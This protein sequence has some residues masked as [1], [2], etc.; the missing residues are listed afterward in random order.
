M[1]INQHPIWT[2]VTPYKTKISGFKKPFH[3]LRIYLAKQVAKLYP[4]SMFVGVTGSVGKTTA[5][6]AAAAVLSQKYKI[7]TT[8]PNLDPIL[9]IPK[10]ILSIRPGIKKVILEMGVEYKGEMDF[11]L[12]LVRPKTAI[13]TRISHA[14]S[15]FLGSLDEIYMEKG[16]LIKQLPS[17]G[18]A[19]LNGDDIYCRKL[20]E[21]TKAAVVFFGRDQKTATIWAG[22][23]KIENFKT[24]FELNYGVER[25]KVNYQLLGEHQIYPALAAAALGVVEDISLIKIKKALESIT[26]AEHRLQALVGP[27]GSTILDDTYNSSP[28]AA[29]A[30]IDTLTQVPARHRILVLGEMRELGVYSEKLHRDLAKKISKEKIDMVILGQGETTYIADELQ[31]LGFIDE[32]LLTNLQNSQIVSYLLKTL[33]RG[34]VC[35][36]KGSRAVRLDEVVKRVAKKNS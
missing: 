26:P 19:I 12:S 2:S 21:E 23:V 28:A 27:N 36:I 33:S 16:Q 7:L 4:T 34:D 17:S 9:N 22:N 15:E 30:A 13:V 8:K 31:S 25:V 20:S 35:L 18:T 5:I 6:S 1:D 3:L 24:T 14:H 32:R 10:T 11:Y 29:E